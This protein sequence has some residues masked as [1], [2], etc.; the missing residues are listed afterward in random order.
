MKGGKGENSGLLRLIEQVFSRHAARLGPVSDHARNFA[1][2]IQEADPFIQ[3]NTGEVCPECEHVC[4]INKHSY[5]TCFDVL[6]LLA[7]G[8][9]V[10]SHMT[11]IA[12][13]EP[14]QFL[15]P[16]GCRL[17]RFL[18]PYRCTWYFCTPLLEHIHNTP[19]RRY[20]AFIS[21]LERMS[22]EREVLVDAFLVIARE[23]GLTAAISP[24]DFY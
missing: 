13:S 8:E 14:C 23:I 20:R 5:H 19:A 9:T 16:G 4:C 15:S 12:D 11:G 3:K 24:H 10:P 17:G 2:L 21:C 1:S 6:Y 22:L 18:R 7:L